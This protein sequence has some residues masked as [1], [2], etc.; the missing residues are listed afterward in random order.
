MNR[1]Y[2]YFTNGEQRGP[3]SIDQLK[4]AGIKPDTLVWTEGMDDWELAEDVGELKSI[5]SKPP[6]IRRNI[7]RVRL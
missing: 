1:E 5:L 7:P 3:L 2:Y 4:M 6:P